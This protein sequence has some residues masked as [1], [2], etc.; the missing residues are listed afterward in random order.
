MNKKPVGKV[1]ERTKGV[2][3][4]VSY[5]K[6]LLQG[7]IPPQV[8]LQFTDHC[9]ALCPQCGMRATEKFQR[10]RISVEDGKRIIDH[11]AAQG[12]E[13]LSFTGG[14]PLIFFDELIQLIRHSSSAGIK[15]IRTGTNGFL[16]RNSDQPDFHSRVEKIA[17]RLAETKLYTFWIS[18]D[19]ASPDVHENMRGMTGLV[20]GIEKALP[21]FHR[22]GIYP[23][24]NLGINRNL[25]DTPLVSGPDGLDAGTIR[26]SFRQF[27]NFVLNLG[28]TIVN[29]CYPMSSEPEE[30]SDGNIYKATST[31]AVVNFSPK[32]KATLFQA[33]YEVI[34][35]YRSR[36]RIFTPRSSLLSLVRQYVGEGMVA[37]PCRGGKDFFFV[38]ACNLE[39]FPCGYRGKESLGKFCEFDFKQGGQ[40]EACRKCD[41]ECFRDPSELTGPLLDLTRQPTRLIQKLITDRQWVQTWFD[42]LRYYRDC[43]YFNSRI[44]PDFKKLEKWSR[45]FPEKGEMK[46]R[47][48]V[49]NELP[50]L[51]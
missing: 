18:L 45:S 42:D 23:S 2:S 12:V 8:V 46:T 40:D 31:D 3:R 33:L 19:S 36:L 32:E 29:A 41:W 50:N 30:D 34:P 48:Q 5:T 20:K 39:T 9:M 1:K 43:N 7:R 37:Y 11:A 51:R 21:V 22:Y 16:F 10:S 38:D 47:L 28:F 15:F 24:A 4:T 6:K 44:A 25:G 35:E 49:A 13:F 14:E 17:E 27:Y 26:K